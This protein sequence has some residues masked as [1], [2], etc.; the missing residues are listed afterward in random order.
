MES[1]FGA[2][3]QAA[4]AAFWEPAPRPENCLHSAPV[5]VQARPGIFVQ[6][7]LDLSPPFLYRL[8]STVYTRTLLSWKRLTAFTDVYANKSFYGFSLTGYADEVEFYTSDEAALDQ[9]LD[10][11]AAFS[12]F[13]KRP[14]Q[15][16]CP[17]AQKNINCPHFAHY[18]F[19]KISR[20]WP[21]TSNFL[22]NDTSD[23]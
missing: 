19:S 1:I 18:L 5:Y 21:Q 6:E 17:F 2:F 10:Y 23:P 4:S 16:L 22:R 13:I 3:D 14:A 7:T 15:K 9:W 8:A 12:T 20:L 11:L